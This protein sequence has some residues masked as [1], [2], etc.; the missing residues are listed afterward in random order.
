MGPAVSIVIPAF[1][2]PERALEAAR[3]ALG[4]ACCASFEIVLVDNDPAGSALGSCASWQ[5]ERA[6]SS[7]NPAL[8]S[9]MRAMPGLARRGEL[10]AFL[11]DDETAPPG[12]LGELPARSARTPR[13][14]GVRSGA[15]ETRRRSRAITTNISTP[16]SRAI[17][18]TPKA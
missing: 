15:H 8:A 4:Q 9:P 12:W 2:R 18:R 13:R 7:T 3:S 5:D 16:S 10:I 1:R 11:D 6:P 17:P 14:R